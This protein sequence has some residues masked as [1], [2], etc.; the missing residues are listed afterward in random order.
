MKSKSIK[1]AAGFTLFSARLL[2]ASG[3]VGALFNRLVGVF[4]YIH[5]ARA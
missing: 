3:W 1:F 4:T 2:L 5:S